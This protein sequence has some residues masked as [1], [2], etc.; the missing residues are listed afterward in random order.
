MKGMKMKPVNGS[1]YMTVPKAT[2]K[3]T[4]PKMAKGMNAKGNTS[5]CPKMSKM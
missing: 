1:G 5:Y 3:M 4:G 2:A